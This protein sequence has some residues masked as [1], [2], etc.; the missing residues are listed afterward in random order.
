VTTRGLYFE[1]FEVGSERISP[2][3]TITETDVVLFAGLSGDY[4]QLHTDEEFAKQTPYGRRIAHGALVFSIATGLAARLGFIEG[5]ALAFRELAWKF[6][7]PVFIG[8]TVHVKAV[9]K[10]L[11]AMAR[12]GGGLVIFD[13]A[14]VNQAGKTVQRGDWHVLVASRPQ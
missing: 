5:T 8:D 10:E 7:L 12:L 3:R 1:Q 9:C 11:K 14:V 4:T 2:A 13:V 6:S